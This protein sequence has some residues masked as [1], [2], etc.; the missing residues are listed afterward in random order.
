MKKSISYILYPSVFYYVLYSPFKFCLALLYDETSM[1]ISLTHK[2]LH[3]TKEKK[4]SRAMIDV[5]VMRKKFQSI[6]MASI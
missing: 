2:N 4:E 6:T 1:F 5:I 3:F